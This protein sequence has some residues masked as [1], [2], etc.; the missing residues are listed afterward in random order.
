[1][2]TLH[3]IIL[4]LILLAC[5]GY[6]FLAAH[7]HLEARQ[8]HLGE[9]PAPAAEALQAH[10]PVEA[11]DNAAASLSETP[12]SLSPENA[13]PG[14]AAPEESMVRPA[15]PA[16]LSPPNM[17]WVETPESGQS[18]GGAPPDVTDAGAPETGT[19]T[20][21]PAQANRTSVITDRIVH[22]P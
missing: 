19:A 4:S 17:H 11:A 22:V 5:A 8:N 16:P 20:P 7:L 21:E 14:E 18:Q 10:E 13:P 2:K 1:M 9:K 3:S 15:L 6:L 12:V